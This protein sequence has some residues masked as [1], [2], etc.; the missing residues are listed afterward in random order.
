MSDNAEDFEALK[1]AIKS[2]NR[3]RVVTIFSIYARRI[4]DA[5]RLQDYA[6]LS[7]YARNLDELQIAARQVIIAVGDTGNANLA[8]LAFEATGLAKGL[9]MV[10]VECLHTIVPPADMEL[11]RKHKDVLG[12]IHFNHGTVLF[13][14]CIHRFEDK[15]FSDTWR[16]VQELSRCQFIDILRG[17]SQRN[18]RLALTPLGEDVYN[19]IEKNN[20]TQ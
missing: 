2:G 14:L 16:I 6:G 8:S 4:A 7:G 19:Q 10:C 1:N 9:R 13:S 18:P 17:R 5:V 20:A 11:A 3:E 12:F 15:S